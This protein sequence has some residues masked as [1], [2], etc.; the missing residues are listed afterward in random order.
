MSLLDNI[1]LWT[2]IPIGA[3]LVTIILLSL[4]FEKKLGTTAQSIAGFVVILLFEIP[5]FLL[6]F[7]PQPPLGLP[8]FL[9]LPIGV[10]IF[11]LAMTIGGLAV[12]QIGAS[13]TKAPSKERNLVTTGVYGIVRH[14]CYLCDVFWP[15]GW[16]II[17]NATYSLIF[18]PL[19]LVL[20]FCLTIVEEKKLVEEYGER[21]EEYRKKVPKRLI[22]GFL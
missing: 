1:W 14:P 21:Y 17:F 16:S 9:S 4:S 3:I 18:T 5:R 6:P 15:V 8:W 7:L 12:F 11:A 2:L 19:W 10:T 20:L 13:A 22:P